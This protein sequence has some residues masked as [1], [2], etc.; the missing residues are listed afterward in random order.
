MLT[1][2]L[3]TSG[4]SLRRTDVELRVGARLREQ[5]VS[6]V[7]ECLV[8]HSPGV[9]QLHGEAR[10][11]AQAADR[12]RNKREHLRVPQ[13]PERARGSLDDR[14]GAVLLPLALV[15][16]GEVEIRLAGILAGRALP[17]A[18]D[19][20]ERLDVLLFGPVR[21]YFSTACCTCNVRVMVA[22]A[23]SRNWTSAAPWSS[24]GRKPVG[25]RKNSRI[26][27]ATTPRTSRRR[28]TC[29]PLPCDHADEP[30]AEAVEAV[31]ELDPAGFDRVG[32]PG[33]RGQARF[34]RP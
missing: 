34:A 12:A 28:T 14:V 6:R 23:G 9:Q 2:R 25:S 32:E 26:N 27:S 20:E 21:K 24:V 1:L 15:V 33:R 4:S 8:G 22:P 16:I 17:A 13:A 29:G 3:A 10:R 31:V 30:V 19:R 11:L 5:L 18:G 7:G